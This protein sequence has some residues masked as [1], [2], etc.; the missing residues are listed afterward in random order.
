MTDLVAIVLGAAL[1]AIAIPLA[2]L[3]YY[4]NGARVDYR[5]ALDAGASAT[6][7]QVVAEKTR[8][9]EH[10]ARVAAEAARDD[11]LKQL[12]TTQAALA[13]AEEHWRSHVHDLVAS[14]STADALAAFEQLFAGLP[15]SPVAAV[16][17]AG[18]QGAAA[19][20]VQPAGAAAAGEARPAS[21]TGR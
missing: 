6:R 11:A 16:A 4:L 10:T 8:D 3:A 1:I 13:A 18:G 21:G 17:A 9:D 19:A 15:A 12:A 14:G 5:T 20:A 7:A 2:M